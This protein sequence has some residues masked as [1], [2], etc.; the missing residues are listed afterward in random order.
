MAA[1]DGIRGAMGGMTAGEVI[2]EVFERV[3]NVGPVEDRKERAKDESEAA[4]KM[5]TVMREDL[6]VIGYG[7]DSFGSSQGQ[8]VNTVGVLRKFIA[9]VVSGKGEDLRAE[10]KKEVVTL[11]TIHQAKGLEWDHVWLVSTL[12]PLLMEPLASSRSHRFDP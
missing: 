2:R 10:R 3:Y 5:C 8:A 4:E 7:Q 6:D 12:L 11:S 9:A 1:V